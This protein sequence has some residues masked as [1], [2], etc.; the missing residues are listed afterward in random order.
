M[1]RFDTWAAFWTPRAPLLGPTVDAPMETLV[2][3]KA[4]VTRAP[5]RFVRHVLAVLGAM[6]VVLFVPLYIVALPF[7]LMWRAVLEATIW[8][9]RAEG[10]DIATGR[11][12]RRPRL[13]SPVWK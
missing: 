1:T 7:V 11:R 3:S 5:S 4:A 12:M 2:T 9:R 13:R 10:D 8:R 6:G